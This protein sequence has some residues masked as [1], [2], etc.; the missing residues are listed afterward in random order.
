MTVANHEVA[1]KFFAALSS[2]DLPD[3]LL[4]DDMTVWTTTSGT[5]GKA[6]YQVGIRMLASVF[7]GGITYTVD[8]LTAEGDRVAAEVQGRG[9]LSNGETYHNFYVYILRIR[10]G[11]VAAVAEHF[12]PDPMLQKIGPLLREAIAKAGRPTSPP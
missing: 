2:G 8:S 4:T 6:R 11:R 9:T 5:Y 7:S 1:R 3:D 12:N 10:A